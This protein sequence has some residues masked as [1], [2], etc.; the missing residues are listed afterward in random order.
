VSASLGG[1]VST[2][3]V[4]VGATVSAVAGVVV[5]TVAGTVVATVVPGLDVPSSLQPA[6]E[7]Q[8]TH[9]DIKGRRRFMVDI[10]A[11]PLGEYQQ[12][13]RSE[14]QSGMARPGSAT[15]RVGLAA[16]R[17]RGRGLV[18]WLLTTHRHLVREKSC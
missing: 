4:V 13:R 15:R 12:L 5:A 17:R 3:A 1:A 6:T 16:L 11:R 7:R 18:G 14:A 8:A 9:N 2:A 10:V